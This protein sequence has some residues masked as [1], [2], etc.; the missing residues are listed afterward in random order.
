MWKTI[1]LVLLVVGMGSFVVTALRVS[2]RAL[3]ELADLLR[4]RGKDEEND[5]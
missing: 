3:P 5:Q 2:V 1:W 4:E